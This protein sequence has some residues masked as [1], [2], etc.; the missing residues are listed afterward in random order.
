[1]KRLADSTGWSIGH[2]LRIRRLGVR[3]SPSRQTNHCKGYL[4]NVRTAPEAFS[5]LVGPS[6]SGVARGDES[7]FVSDDY[8]LGSVSGGELGEEMAYV[9]F[10]RCVAHEQ[11]VGEFCV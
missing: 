3:V 11:C 8:E 9:C 5:Q 6:A 10:R 7:G 1:M 2:E 4:V